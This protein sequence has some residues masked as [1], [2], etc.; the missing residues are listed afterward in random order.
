MGKQSLELAM[1]QAKALPDLQAICRGRVMY[2]QFGSEMHHQFI[3][4]PGG[5]AGSLARKIDQGDQ[6]CRRLCS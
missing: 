5:R 2:G 1:G 4:Y 6:L 3:M